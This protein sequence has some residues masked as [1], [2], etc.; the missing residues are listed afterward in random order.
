MSS[1]SR[2]IFIIV[3]CMAVRSFAIV[4][5]PNICDNVHCR[6][7]VTAE[8][9]YGVFEPTGGFCGCCPLCVTIIPAGGGCV[10]LRGVPQSARCIESTS[11]I[12]GTCQPL[13]SY[14]P[15]EE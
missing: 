2:L 7:D 12:N 14:S 11:C 8:N 9:C 4:C 13:P 15:S 1:K 10:V 5:T 3:V 6:I